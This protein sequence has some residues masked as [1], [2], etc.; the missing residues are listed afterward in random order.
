VKRLPGS[1]DIV[2]IKNRLTI[3]VDGAFWHGFNW[4]E[5]RQKMK[6]NRGFW[7]PKIE[8]NMQRDAENNIKLIEQGYTVMRFWDFQV[9][10]DFYSC[11]KTITRFID[12]QKSNNF[13]TALF[14]Y[15]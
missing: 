7:I 13:S 15:E 11:L 3:F 10:N 1:P 8:R 9:K 2:F 4:G 12:E 14:L 5:K 6:S